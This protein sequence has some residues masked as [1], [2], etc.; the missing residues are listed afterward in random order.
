MGAG[1]VRV[2]SEGERG[3]RGKRRKRLKRRVRGRIAGE[4][5]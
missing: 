1:E 5:G 2:K 3:R 4:Q